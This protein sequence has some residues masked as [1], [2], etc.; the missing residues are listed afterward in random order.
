MRANENKKIFSATQPQSL[1]K[2]R[3]PAPALAAPTRSGRLLV[4]LA[5]QDTAIFRF[6][7]E[8]YDHTAYFTVLEPKTALLKIV[9]S[10]HLENETR[11][12]LAQM[13]QSLPFCVEEW[14]LGNLPQESKKTLR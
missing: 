7:L 1:R 13:A 5:P 14:P 8:A 3:K 12:A 6:L 9:F 11:T 10:P 2:R 4:R